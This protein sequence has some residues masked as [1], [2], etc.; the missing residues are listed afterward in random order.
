MG[1]EAT[2][3][4]TVVSVHTSKNGNTFLNF[5]ADYPRQTFTAA[6]LDPHHPQA[7]RLQELK[8]RRVRV[9]GLIRLYHGQPEIVIQEPSQVVPLE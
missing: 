5:G 6:L 3:V 2:V 8:G 4:G 1:E 7:A 9:H